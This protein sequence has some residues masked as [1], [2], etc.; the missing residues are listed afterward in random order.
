M[1]LEALADTFGERARPLGVL[2]LDVYLADLQQRHLRRLPSK[3]RDGPDE[4]PATLPIDTTLAGRAFQ[5][6]TVHK[7]QDDEGLYRLWVPVLDGTERLGV[8]ELIVTDVGEATLRRCRMLAS[9]AALVIV[10]K[11][12][13]SDVYSQVQRTRL[14][15][16]QAEMEW[17]FMA[18]PTFATE[19]VLVA[20]ALEPAY[21][22]GGDA[23][24]YSLLGDRLSVAVIDAA[25]HDLTAGLIASVAMAG[26]RNTRRSGG[27]LLDLVDCVD[28]AIAGQFDESRFATAL[29]CELDIATGLLTWVV[30][31][32]PPPLLIRENQVVKELVREP[33]LPLGIRCGDVPPVVHSEQ[34]QPGDRLLLYTDGVV[35][36]RGAD[37]R[38]FGLKR[39]SDFVIRNSARGMSAPETVRR[40]THAV[41]DYQQG[42]LSDDST[43]LLLEWMSGDAGR[44][45]TLRGDEA[46]GSP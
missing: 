16:M 2:Q 6:I 3:R 45:L 41:V 24:D 43:I 13:Y 17:A 44:Q 12:A 20:A 40:L 36:G 32:H 5:S 4:P 7:V 38:Q 27:D 29:I 31:G 33:H 18:P 8:L 22:A 15:A 21:E 37:G 19:R 9:L 23:Y 34:L 25:G 10:S 26:C 46:L 14:L 11:S 30:C 42:R 39:L 35:E 28:H 1:P